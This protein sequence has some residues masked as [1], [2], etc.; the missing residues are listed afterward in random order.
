MNHPP[1]WLKELELLA[2]KFTHLGF[3]PD[4]AAMTLCELA[5]LHHYLTRLA[6]TAP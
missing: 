4:L 2:W 6:A 1:E 3:G 5:G